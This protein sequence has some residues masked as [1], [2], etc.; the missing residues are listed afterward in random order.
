MSRILHFDDIF[1]GIYYN[2]IMKIKITITI[3]QQVNLVVLL[4]NLLNIT[5]VNIIIFVL[6]NKFHTGVGF[7][8]LMISF[9]VC[10]YYN[11]IIAYS[12]HFIVNSMTSQ[13]PWADC[14]HDWNTDF[15]R[16]AS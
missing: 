6:F 7:C 9:L 11:V 12:L 8:M 4:N 14:G 15:C 5:Y 16:D 13:L 2:V 1:P 3:A 10:I